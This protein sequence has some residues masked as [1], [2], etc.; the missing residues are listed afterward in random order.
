MSCSMCNFAEEIDT[1]SLENNAQVGKSKEIKWAEEST[2]RSGIN[3]NRNA[4]WLL[5]LCTSS[6]LLLVSVGHFSHI[7]FWA[8]WW[9]ITLNLIL[10]VG[11]FH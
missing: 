3:L 4:T 9:C 2:T 10:S 5:S 1:F 6:I 7:F 8:P 11:W